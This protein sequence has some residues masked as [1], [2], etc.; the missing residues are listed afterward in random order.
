M[1]FGGSDEKIAMPLLLIIGCGDPILIWE[2]EGYGV[3]SSVSQK[4][5]GASVVTFPF[6][7]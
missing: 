5:T 1:S 2:W 4:D 7:D 6:P 3:T